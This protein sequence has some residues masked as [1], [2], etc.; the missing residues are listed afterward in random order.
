MPPRLGYKK[1]MINKI[2]LTLEK[3]KEILRCEDVIW[4]TG[5]GILG[6]QASEA[7]GSPEAR[8]LKSTWVKIKRDHLKNG[9]IV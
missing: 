6:T 3:C 4:A 7:V 8:S 1:W 5:Y 2:S 9:R